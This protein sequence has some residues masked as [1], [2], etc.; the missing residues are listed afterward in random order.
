MTTTPERAADSLSAQDVYTECK[1]LG[2]LA[3]VGLAAFVLIEIR[4]RAS[5]GATDASARA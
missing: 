1:I 3:R 4:Q 2:F 5:V